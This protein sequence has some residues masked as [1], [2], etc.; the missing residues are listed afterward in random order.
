MRFPQRTYRYE[1]LPP[2]SPGNVEDAHVQDHLIKH[3]FGMRSLIGSQGPG[4]RVWDQEGWDRTDPPVLDLPE[5]RR[6]A[7]RI[8]ELSAGG[9]RC[10]VPRLSSEEFGGPAVASGEQEFDFCLRC[11]ELLATSCRGLCSDLARGYLAAT[12]DVLRLLDGD[13]GELV[14]RPALM[15]AALGLACTDPASLDGLH[16]LWLGWQGYERDVFVARL[17]AWSGTR[18]EL[19]VNEG[20]LRWRTTYRQGRPDSRSRLTFVLDA[21]ARRVPFGQPISLASDSCLVPRPWWQRC[22]DV[23]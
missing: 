22:Q 15:E 16:V 21:P 9:H 17:T 11:E 4:R 2:L 6:L 23:H 1:G 20:F 8:K 14:S 5:R 3:P 18:V 7:G 19:Y 10:R 13:Q 12:E